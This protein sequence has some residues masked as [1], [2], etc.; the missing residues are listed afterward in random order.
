[1]SEESKCPFNH[2][3]GVGRTNRDWWPNQLRLDLLH[4]HSP[5]ADPMDKDFDYAKAFASLDYKAL[6]KDLVKLMTDS[7]EWWPADFG[8]Y[9][10]RIPTHGDRSITF[11]PITQ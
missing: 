4:Q 10:L 1:M 9:G 11:M 6:K 2:T 8:H 3:A 5:G 7:Q